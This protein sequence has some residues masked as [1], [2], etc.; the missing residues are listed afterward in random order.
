ML[1][2]VMG[3]ETWETLRSLETWEIWRPGDLEMRNIVFAWG[4][5][6]I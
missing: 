1:R 4:Q 5:K 3:R 6:T 2:R